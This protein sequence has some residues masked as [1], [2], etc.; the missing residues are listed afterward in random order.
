MPTVVQFR[1]GTTAQNDAFTGAVGELSID[2]QKDTL[3]VHD[4][5][6]AGGFELLQRNLTNQTI[7]GNMIPD[8]DSAYDLGSPTNKW[9]SLYISGQTIYI[10]DATISASGTTVVLPSGS[11][12]AGAGSLLDSAAAL[13][14]LSGGTGITYNS[15]T[16]EFT[17]TDSEIVHDNLSGFVA[18]EHVAHSS[19]SITAGAG[20]TGGG[21][22][23]TTR[24]LN[25][26]AGTG[27]TVNADNVAIGQDVATTANVTFATV[28][29][30]GNVTVGGNLT[31][32]GTTTTLNTATLDVE[33]L[34]ITI[35]KGAADSAAANGAG[36]TVDGANAYIIYDATGDT[37]NVNKA[38]GGGFNAI[39]NYT[40]TQLTE[41]DNL[42]YT[43]ARADSDFDVRLAT[44][45]TT[46]VAE[47]DNLY[48]T[49]ARFDSALGD[50]LSQ[51]TIRGY[52]SAAG[53][54][55]YN[56]S[57]GE[58]SFD[59]ENVYTQANFDSDFNT[60]LD[61][62]AID[63]VGLTYNST[64]NTL[65]IDSAELYA[66][67]DHDSFRD[68]VADEHV[69]HTSVSITAGSGLTGG[70]DIST[71]RTINIGQGTGITV[72][73][74][75]ISTNDGEIVH[76]NLSGFV[77]NEHIDHSTVTITA[78]SGLTGGGDITT[79]RTLN[80]GQGT[81]I[82]VG[83]D[84]ISTN[85]AQIV[86]DNLSG[87]VAD[88]HVAHTSVTLTAGTGL[89][90]GGDISSSRTFNIDSA[91]LYANFAHDDFHDYVAD[92]HIAHSTVS[93][94]AGSGL[95]GGGTIAASRTIN[96]GEG[97]G[98]T[99][100]ADAISTNDAEIV[101]DNLS[102]FVSD[103]HVAHSNVTL[104]AGVGLNGGGNIASSR[105][106]NIDSA[107][108]YANFAHDDFH[109]YV[110]DEHIAHSGVT[111]TAGSGLT[112]GGTIAASR[113]INIGQ[114][115]GITVGAD[116]ISTNDAQI[117]HDNLSGF[118]ANEHI[119]HSTVTIT[120]GSGLT[121]GGSIAASRT[122]NIGEGTGITVSADAISTNDAEIVHDNLSGFVAD[123]HVAHS[124]VSITAGS[125]LTGGG[126]IAAS[127]TI[128][129]GE[130]TGITVS[131]DAISTND[132]EIVH[133]NLSGFVADEHIAHSGVTMTA[134][135]GLTGGGTI[136]ASR[137]FNVGAGTGVTVSA[138][139]V[140]IGQ[141]VATTADVAFNTVTTTGNVTIGGNLQVTGTT[142][143]VNSQSLEVTDNM[144]YM[145][146]GE[147]D[148]S[149]TQ[150]IDVGWAANVN[151]GGSYTHVGM[152]RDA[153]DDRFKVFGAYTPEPDA[154]VEIDTGHAS[155]ALADFQAANFYGNLTGDVTGN[156]STATTLQTARTIGLTGDVTATG[157]SFNGSGNIT[158]TTAMAANSVD[159]GTHTTGSYVAQGATSGNGISGSVNSEGGT[160]TVTSNATNANTGS[161]IVFR[162]A[163]GN[164]SAGTVTAALSGN[165]T[166]ATTLQTA[167]TI[168]GVS[169]NG[170]ANITVEPYIENDDGTNATRYLTFVDN[171]TASYKR[172][173]EDA[174][175]TYNPSTNVLTAGTFS[176]ALSG[177][178]TTATTLATARTIALTG[179]VTATGVSFDG[180]GNISLTTAMAANSVDLGTHTT[181]NY[182][183]A[184]ATSGNGISG[185]VSSEGGTFTVTSNAT[186]ANTAST[187]VFR[188]ASG[189]FSA[190]TITASLNGN[191][192]T[193]TSATTATTAT[194][195]TA[196]ANNATN[197]TTYITFVDG[198][199]GAQGIETDTGLT[200]NPSTNTI[201]ASTFSGALS[202]NA[203]TA[204]TLQTARTIGG[205]SFDG[206]ANINLPGV[207]TTGNQNT[208]GN[209]ATAT[210]WA[211]GRTISLT[212]EVTGT[213]GS[214][215]G[216]G[217]LSFATTVAANV[218]GAN[219][220]AVTGN[221]TTAQF[222]R[223][224][225]D[226]TFTWA[227]PTDTNT[228]YSAGNGISL[229][230]TTFSVAAGT[231]LTQDAS[232][233]SIS[234]GGV[235]S[236]QLA[237]ATSLVIYDAAGTALKTLYGAGS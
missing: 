193:A 167:R 66:N 93:I 175:L 79:T 100:S 194:N 212:G 82:T 65:S 164:F 225:G 2:T 202:G 152:F 59:V 105:T 37:W 107:E 99:V 200:Y 127:R 50:E 198:A 156:A 102:G 232:G 115:T 204:T 189:N 112:G 149:P 51:A 111:I 91:E 58:F 81:G 146:A 45:T 140:S 169:F 70:G 154:A 44:K 76:D 186:N 174:N 209:A 128:N 206:S 177:N 77:A 120:A 42:Y 147:S 139:A 224:D 47:G 32:N 61:A 138:D 6:T 52:F 29:T 151:D 62:A 233:L 207:N 116:A 211:T 24:T 1:R 201:T 188:D 190:G 13:A 122:I 83:A 187:I 199:T 222:L 142:T 221:G 141:D 10:G 137:T 185:S 210:K 28:E 172:L 215:D 41:G 56:S 133:D 108:L 144:I 178:A 113:T 5:S 96:I 18:D 72:G 75:A 192:S 165:A 109:D 17:T 63:G 219:E 125:G 126:T 162:D 230:G 132:A 30:T 23:T 106:F 131:A 34:N 184:G 16:G 73:A 57:T 14:L 217:N 159:L 195:V 71:T 157:V 158:L 213:S 90:G 101:H 92:E 25:I 78:G 220:L 4:G 33:D 87:F 69:A 74:D 49:R 163:S 39:Q 68:Y 234:D 35:A 161:T 153:T 26:G 119:D 168:N 114:G 196:T 150:S 191:A 155:F 38:F 64:T 228:T 85:D 80:I 203:T 130:G 136:A 3:R 21:D 95:T 171:S 22:I 124:S 143:T 55:S 103:E 176:G 235:T 118:V 67:F 218:I 97:T 54:L 237:S 20:L 166:T 117:V 15:G 12:I 84:A 160:F 236:T 231:G 40:T 123:E 134:G 205:V 43:T 110:A 53:D 86:H 170:S 60:S 135:N 98:I 31:V 48:Y 229:S 197:E 19:V 88:E 179:D 36:I 173:N 148:G 7:G 104:T 11:T 183:A 180:S 226:G 216:S 129:V 214:F 9:R 145:N 208:T 227:T 89:N 182:V 94:T 8:T 27:V 121:G 181:G 46:N 223:S